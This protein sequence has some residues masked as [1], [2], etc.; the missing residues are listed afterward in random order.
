MS[1]PTLDYEPPPSVPKP[2]GSI[3]EVVFAAICFSAILAF[4]VM[5][6]LGGV[7]YVLSVIFGPLDGGNG[8]LAA[9]AIALTIL[10]SGVVVFATVVTLTVRGHLLRLDDHRLR[11]GEFARRSDTTER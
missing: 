11:R 7:V 1:Q 4:A 9:L 5:L 6:A 3:V 2:R 10:L 8:Y